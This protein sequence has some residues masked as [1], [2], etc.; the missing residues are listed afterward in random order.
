MFWRVFILSS[1][2]YRR[3][4]CIHLTKSR[5]VEDVLFYPKNEVMASPKIEIKWDL[6]SNVPVYIKY[7]KVIWL[8]H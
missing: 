2:N 6:V 8:W 3:V 5:F 7:D 1:L 4:Y